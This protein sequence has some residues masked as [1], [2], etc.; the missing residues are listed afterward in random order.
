MN[1]KRIARNTYLEYLNR[2]FILVVIRKKARKWNEIQY[3]TQIFPSALQ[4][5]LNRYIEI[6]IIKKE[7]DK[8]IYINQSKSKDTILKLL[9]MTTEFYLKNP[10]AIEELFK[11]KEYRQKKTYNVLF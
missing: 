9:D 4:R 7:N 2:V 1:E 10:K 11:L 8:F 5:T 6:G 3:L